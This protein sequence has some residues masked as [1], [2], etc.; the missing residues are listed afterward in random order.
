MS[1]DVYLDIDA[2][3]KI[4]GTGIY[5]RKNGQTVELTVEEAEELYP[6]EIIIDQEFE[7]TT[8]FQNNITHNLVPMATKAG[9]Y[10]ILW[11]PEQTDINIAEDLIIPLLKGLVKLLNDPIGYRKLNPENGWGTYEQLVQF[12]KDYLKACI[13]YPE[14]KVTASV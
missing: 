6:G 7:T 4:K 2:P 1:L 14:A 10:K 13:D 8:I 11:H 5:V 9:L 3:I 12:V